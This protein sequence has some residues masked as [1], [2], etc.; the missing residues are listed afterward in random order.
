MR[1]SKF[2]DGNQFSADDLIDLFGASHPNI[3]S[4]ARDLHSAKACDLPACVSILDVSAADVPP[5]LG[6]FATELHYCRAGLKLGFHAAWFPWLTID[7][8]PLHGYPL[9]SGCAR[10]RSAIPYVLAVPRRG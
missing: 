1:R 4:G 7:R 10:F 9:K 2:S 5:I 3:E 6:R 8:L